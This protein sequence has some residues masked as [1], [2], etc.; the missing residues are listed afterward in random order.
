MVFHTV[1]L[2]FTVG[3][4]CTGHCFCNVYLNTNAIPWMYLV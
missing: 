2:R 1:S 3:N 4:E